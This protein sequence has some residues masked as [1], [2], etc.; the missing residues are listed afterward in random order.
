MA[1]TLFPQP[2]LRDNRQ[3]DEAERHQRAEIYQCGRGDQIK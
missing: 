3:I 1:A 2:E